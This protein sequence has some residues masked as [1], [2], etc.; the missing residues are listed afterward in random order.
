MPHG[1]HLTFFDILERHRPDFGLY[2]A[3]SFPRWCCTRV[4]VPYSHVVFGH[5]FQADLFPAYGDNDT[6][7]AV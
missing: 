7:N 6:G 5:L 3:E 1:G 4:V 2:P